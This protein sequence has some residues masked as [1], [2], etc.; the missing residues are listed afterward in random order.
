MSK[1]AFAFFLI[2]LMQLNKPSEAE[3][4]FYL[5]ETKG[6]NLQGHGSQ[7][8][9][10]GEDYDYRVPFNKVLNIGMHYIMHH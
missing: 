1:Y 4:K 10:D 6:S 8:D 3:G 5:V 7:E 9:H 2:Y